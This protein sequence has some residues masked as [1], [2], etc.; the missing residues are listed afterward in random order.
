VACDE[1][2]AVTGHVG[3]F[4]QEVS[5]GVLV[6]ERVGSHAFEVSYSMACHVREDQRFMP[7]QRA[8]REN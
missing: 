8:W 3:V 2:R 7:S 1:E 4:Q 5:D 6:G